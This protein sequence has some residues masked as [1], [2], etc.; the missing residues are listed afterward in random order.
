MRWTGNA[1]HYNNTHACQRQRLQVRAPSAGDAVAAATAARA[2]PV[3]RL[4]PTAR[5]LT[6]PARSRPARPPSRPHPPAGLYVPARIARRTLRRIPGERGRHAEAAGRAPQPGL[7]NPRARQQ[8][9]ASRSPC[10]DPQPTLPAPA[11]AA[12]AGAWKR[13]LRRRGG[14]CPMEC[15]YIVISSTHL[16][17][18][19]FRNIKGV[20]RGPLS[21]N[22]N[23]TLVISL[24]LSVSVSLTVSLCLNRLSSNKAYRKK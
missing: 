22:G 9:T 12:G 17:N 8:R 16:S 15:Y 21:K 4:R 18:G 1:A 5:A 11:A 2:A 23:K 6:A 13:R 24:S 3:A 7:G 10:R 20:F 14:G 19:H